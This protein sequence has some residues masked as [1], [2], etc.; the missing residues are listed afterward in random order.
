MIRNIRQKQQARSDEVLLVNAKI[1][2]HNI[3]NSWLKL[4]IT[5]IRKLDLSFNYFTRL[6]KEMGSKVVCFF[7]GFSS[8]EE[9]N[10]SNNPIE[11]VHPTNFQTNPRLKILIMENSNINKDLNFRFL[12]NLKSLE[13]LSIKGHKVHSLTPAHFYKIVPKESFPH[14][15]SLDIRSMGSLTHCPS[16]KDREL[17][18]KTFPALEQFNGRTILSSPQHSPRENR[19]LRS[20]PKVIKFSI[21]QSFKNSEAK[22]FEFKALNDRK[23]NEVNLLEKSKGTGLTSSF[24]EFL[25]K[26]S[27]LKNFEI[28][29][30]SPRK[31]SASKNDQD[32]ENLSDFEEQ[33]DT[34]NEKVNRSPTSH[35][36]FYDSD[37]KDN[38]FTFKKQE[39]KSVSINLANCLGKTLKLDQK[40]N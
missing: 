12:K 19:H 39:I 40:M 8:L 37:R 35:F 27:S 18:V 31:L 20:S 26:S 30:I 16:S 4:K 22:V 32:N 23:E 7:D 13:H 6:Y 17:M 28:N 1:S 9:L 33:F 38:L 10:L 3:V 36:R 2:E 25:I 14:L 34:I 15:R 29:E 11:F 5:T 24:G 21:E